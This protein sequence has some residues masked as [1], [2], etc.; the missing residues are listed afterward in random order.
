MGQKAN[1][2]TLVL[3]YLTTCPLK[4]EGTQIRTEETLITKVEKKK[5]TGK[6]L[7]SP[8]TY[9][10]KKQNL[11]VLCSLSIYI[12]VSCICGCHGITRAPGI[13]TKYWQQDLA[14]VKEIM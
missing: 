5:N 9:N 8:N 12:K 14:E 1:Y 2:T 6:F 3:F 10:Y 11:Q 4:Q 13:F 7:Y